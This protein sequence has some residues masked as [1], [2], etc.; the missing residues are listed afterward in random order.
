V[1]TQ[2]IEIFVWRAVE[3]LLEREAGLLRRLVTDAVDQ[4]PSHL[5]VRRQQAA[6]ALTVISAREESLT[7]DLAEG[8]LDG[9][10]YATAI[11]QCAAHRAAANDLLTQ[12]DG[13]TYLAR[14]I[15]IREGPG[16]GQ[17]R[18]ITLQESWA[19]LT[20]AEQ[21]RVLRA[22]SPKITLQNPHRMGGLDAPR[23]QPARGIFTGVTLK[24]PATTGAASA[25]ARGMAR[26]LV[27]HPGYDLVEGLERCGWNECE[28]GDGVRRWTSGHEAGLG[29]P[30]G[31][32]EL[33]P[34]SGS[35]ATNVDTR[36]KG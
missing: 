30:V 18:W 7:D 9:A 29:V 5:D 21:R 28:D 24:R 15:T 12:V 31:H 27:D 10:A 19:R 33:R 13:W 4:L 36:P 22:L 17:L 1:W 25:I 32:I 3:Q 16:A 6:A 2:Q 8:R 11:A 20:R 26:L 23:E 34:S 14:L 35:G